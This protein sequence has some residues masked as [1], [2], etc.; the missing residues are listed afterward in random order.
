LIPVSVRHSSRSQQQRERILDAA[1]RCFIESGFHAASVAHI[2]ETAQM[3]AGLIYRYF[4]NKNAIV[5]AIID[6]HLEEE[7]HRSLDGLNSVD[8]MV[9]AALEVFDRWRRMDDPRMNA[10]LCLEMTAECTRNPEIA[11]AT[12]GAN[13]SIRDGIQRAVR[14]IAKADGVPLTETL[15]KRNAMILQ[16][17]VEGLALRVIREPEM[18]R[19]AL[20]AALDEL[21]P[22][23]M[24]R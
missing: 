16:C 15:V 21:I 24:R 13:S 14:R 20:K 3:S 11:S 19:N 10:A 12:H 18:D 2:A 23:L 22:F 7:A 4:K 5:K 17:L 1:E 9:R 6:R 8:D